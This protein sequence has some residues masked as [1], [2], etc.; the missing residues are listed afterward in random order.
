MKP[1]SAA[2]LA[3]LRNR[4]FACFLA[5]N[6]LGTMALAMQA[7]SLGWQIYDLSGSP[8]QLG[9]VG[10]MEFL[11]PFCLALFTGHIADRFDRR[12]IVALGLLAE[13]VA[14]VYLVAT[15]LL[16][17]VSVF[18]ILAVA[19]AF[20]LARAISTPAQ[21]AMM[22]TLMPAEDFPSA[23]AWGSI[24]WQ[25]ASIGGPALGGLLYAIDP[26]VV[27]AATAAALLAS[28]VA[29]LCVTPRPP[30][31][32]IERPDL[33]SLLAGVS[34]IFRHKLLLGAISLDLFAVLF[35]GAAALLPVFAKDILHVGPV[36]LGILRSAPGIGAVTTALLLT[37]WPLRRH[38]GRRLF[39][40]VGVFGIMAIGFGLS[41]S[42]WLSFALL[43]VMGA[44]DN[45]SVYVRGSLVPLATPDRLRGRVVAV[46][47]VFIGASN[48]LG[49]FVAGSGAALLGPVL[50]VLTGGTLTLGV[51]L[52][53]S[54]LFPSL[55]SVDRMETVRAD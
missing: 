31:E 30:R 38:V 32:E 19:F 42:Y 16:G 13:T 47:S 25:V 36:G 35:S 7:V 33:A 11:P 10:L 2:G 23:V 45:I 54:A 4:D 53:W 41:A 44:A 12:R 55:R 14:A 52:V 28:A 48:E 15:I 27:Y 34:M 1:S 8:F 37:Q 40:A 6:F 9:L 29:I 3:A 43:L 17:R 39:L 5:A 51:A 46:E 21:R 49:A 26:A 50:A 18:G 22:P 20:G 24:S